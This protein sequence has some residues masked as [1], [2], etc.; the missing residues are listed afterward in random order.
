MEE[1]AR[2]LFFFFLF[3]LFFLKLRAATAP[4]NKTEAKRETF[5]GRYILL[6][7]PSCLD[8][9]MGLLTLPASDSTQRSMPS[10][11][12]RP[13]LNVLC[14]H[15]VPGRRWVTTR[16]L[17]SVATGPASPRRWTGLGTGDTVR[18]EWDPTWCGSRRMAWQPAKIQLSGHQPAL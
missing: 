14:R 7:Y 3:F 2:G 16:T 1:S 5:A 17:G 4:Q 11:G 8:A 12:T 10:T 15:L 13:F 18:T 9:E 6:V